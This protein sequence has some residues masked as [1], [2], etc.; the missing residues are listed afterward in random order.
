MMKRIRRLCGWIQFRVWLHTAYVPI[1]GGD[2]TEEE[3]AEREKKEKE[4]REEREREAA[5]Q[6]K[7]PW[8][9]EEENFDAERAWKLIQDLRTD[10]SKLKSER[11]D[12]AAKLKE[13][14]DSQKSEEEKRQEQAAEDKKD[15]VES[16]REAARLRV[17]LKKGLTETQAKRLVGDDEEALEKDA[18]ELLADFKDDEEG[19][20][21]GQDPPRRPR[22]RLRTGAAP[23]SEP[24]EKD[25][26]KLAEAVPRSF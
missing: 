21:E 24:E 20:G 25:P 15:A 14:E 23:S 9:D 7:P 6:K 13:I 26:A 22:E 12:S 2:E 4:E 17:A 1:A 3:K 16:K 19:E 18:D 11:D 5:E 8:G 10:N